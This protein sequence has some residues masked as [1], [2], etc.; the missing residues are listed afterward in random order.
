MAVPLDSSL[1]FDS[2]VTG[3]RNRLAVSAALR[4][5][6][7]PGTYNPLVLFGPAGVGKTH[8]L[9][10]IGNKALAV[11]PRLNVVCEP[12]AAFAERLDAAVAAGRL[13]AFRRECLR[14]DLLLLEDAQCLSGRTRTQDELLPLWGRM[15][16]N[17]AQVVVT[18][19][20]PPAEIDR[21]NLRLEARFARVLAAELQP[22]AGSP[23][24]TRAAGPAS[25]EPEYAAGPDLLLGPPSLH[26]D[27][28]PGAGVRV[29]AAPP[30][31]AFAEAATRPAPVHGSGPVAR[32]TPPTGEEDPF[33]SFLDDITATVAEVVDSVPWRAALG[34][35]MLHWGGAGIRTWRLE[36]ALQREGP[37][38]LALIRS[39][40][41]DAERLQAIASELRVLLP[42]AA[43][44]PVLRDP[45]RLEEAEALLAGARLQRKAPSHSDAEPAAHLHGRPDAGRSTRSAD[46]AP[47]RLLRESVPP[48]PDPAA[49]G[50][51]MANAA[52]VADRG[53][54]AG[55]EPMPADPWFFDAEKLDWS[56]IALPD[57]LIEELG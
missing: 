22:P 6:E 56:W 9:H 13:E 46:P 24:T 37:D 47:R 33:G 40:E 30:L 51:R 29:A 57:R 28:A 21:L 8:L 32:L 16:Q 41:A 18:A 11:R 49:T 42:E 38:V 55:T 45:D 27:P 4:A 50:A 39:F 17:G 44:S 23:P 5:A 26:A 52:A 1:T 25:R 12:L 31:R 54:A 35:A 20:R 36:Q 2:F 3:P 19:D 48:S 43:A 14:I 10:A 7:A 15:G 34:E 53:V